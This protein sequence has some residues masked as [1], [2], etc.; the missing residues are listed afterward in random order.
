MSSKPTACWDTDHDARALRVQN[1]PGWS[2]LLRPLPRIRMTITE[3]VVPE[4]TEDAISVVV[5]EGLLKPLG[6]PPPSGAGQRL[7]CF[8]SIG[9]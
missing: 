3:P 7:G 2:S 8:Q 5:S 4:F 1:A 6:H 9:V